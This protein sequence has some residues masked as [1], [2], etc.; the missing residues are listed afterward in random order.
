MAAKNVPRIIKIIK[1]LSKNKTVGIDTKLLDSGVIDSLMT[2]KLIEM[3]EKEFSVSIPNE[4]FTHFNFNTIKA[5][6]ELVD[7][8]NIK[9]SK[10]K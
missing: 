6:S 7:R 4:E 10:K 8:L 9:G 1:D 2:M 5:M 3:L